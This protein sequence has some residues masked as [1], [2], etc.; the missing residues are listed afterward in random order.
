MLLIRTAFSPCS[1]INWILGRRIRRNNLFNSWYCWLCQRYEKTQPSRGALNYQCFEN[2]QKISRKTSENFYRKEKNEGLSSIINFHT[3][4]QE[5]KCAGVAQEPISFLFTH[6]FQ[7]SISISLEIIG[8]SQ[9]LLVILGGIERGLWK[10]MGQC[11][12]FF[13][14]LINWVTLR[15]SIFSF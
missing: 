14:R 7:C 1:I 10:E 8:K 6:F 12:Y 3:I 2:I 5:N 13:Q 4:S 15:T 9:D 11:S